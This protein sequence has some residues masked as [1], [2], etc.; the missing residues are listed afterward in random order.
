MKDAKIEAGMLMKRVDSSW[1]MRIPHDT[2]EEHWP[3]SAGDLSYAL[4]RVYVLV[5]VFHQNEQRIEGQ[6]PIP[7][8]VVEG[9]ITSGTMSS[10][11]TIPVS[12]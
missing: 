1:L 2:H 6:R 3:I 12:P 10:I 5:L 9:T 7:P 8:G 4:F 11:V